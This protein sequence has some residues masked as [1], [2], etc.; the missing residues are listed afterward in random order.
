VKGIRAQAEAQDTKKGKKR[1]LKEESTFADPDSLERELERIKWYLWHGNAFDALR[2]TREMEDDLEWVEELSPS[3]QKLLQAARAFNVS[4]TRNQSFL[5]NYG[6][7]H[8]NGETISTAFV[9]STV[10]E[11][12]SRRFVKKQ[13]VRWTKRGTHHLLQ[14]RVQTLN[15][16]LRDT[17]RALVPFFVGSFTPPE[18]KATG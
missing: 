18:Q 7:R 2:I 9:E 17:D 12:I 5:V 11:V 13:Q 15:K 16:T 10:D 4:I 3:I 14:V 6:D 1:R 8:R